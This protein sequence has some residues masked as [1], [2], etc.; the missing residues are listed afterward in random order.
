MNE[1]DS[2]A[3]AYAYCGRLVRAHD[4]DHYI[5]SLFAPAERRPA[6]RAVRLRARDRPCAGAGERADG[7]DDPPAMVAGGARRI[8]R[9]GGG[10][11]SGDDGVAGRGARQRRRAGA[12]SPPRSRR[13]QDELY[14]KSAV[15]AVAAVFTVAA[16]MLGAEGEAVVRR[17]GRCGEGRD[18]CCELMIPNRR[19]RAIKRSVRG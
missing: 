4:K 5:A 15:G 12:R 7:G 11:P 8:A 16:R 3:E 2:I 17:G 6:V 13:A 9:G 14:D 19:V 1:P 18:I 10:G